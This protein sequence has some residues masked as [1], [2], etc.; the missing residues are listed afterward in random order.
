MLNPKFKDAASSEWAR[1]ATRVFACAMTVVM[2]V[3]T[4]VPLRR[5]W[6]YPSAP[7]RAVVSEAQLGEWIEVSDIHL[8]CA[9]ALNV[10]GPSRVVLA[11]QD[12]KPFLLG[13]YRFHCESSPVALAGTIERLP[14]RAIQAL[15]DRAPGLLA[16]GGDR[17]L[18]ASCGPEDDA[19]NVVA[20]A[21]LVAVSAFLAGVLTRP[22]AWNQG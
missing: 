22:K 16:M 2:L 14:F 18:C 12:G 20:G 8:E 15:G 6:N 1:K 10:E 13:N 19:G 3:I 9:E 21:I 17:Y 5:W 11:F 7:K 4:W